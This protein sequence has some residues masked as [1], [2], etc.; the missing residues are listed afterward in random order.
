M[1]SSRVF[2]YAILVEKRLTFNRKEVPRML[3]IQLRKITEADLPLFFEFQKDREACRMAAF[4]S[5]EPDNWAHF[6]KHWTKILGNEEIVKR[7]IV[8]EDQAAG[9]ISCFEQCGEKEVGFWIDRKHW[10]KGL[11]TAALS[12]FLTIVDLRPLHARAAKDNIGSLKVLKKCGFVVTGESSGFSN[13]RQKEV[14][15]FILTL[16]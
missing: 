14:E 6:L 5:K 11:A 10:G 8:M 9:N 7:T 12:E 4:T 2:L 16:A 15:E 1:V 3:Q 13:A